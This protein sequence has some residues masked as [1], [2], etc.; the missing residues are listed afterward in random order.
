VGLRV[1]S[2]RAISHEELFEQ[3]RQSLFCQISLN[4]GFAAE[5]VESS[6]GYAIPFALQWLSS[7]R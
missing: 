1:H 6:A 7:L 2:R 5:S 3:Y 4:W